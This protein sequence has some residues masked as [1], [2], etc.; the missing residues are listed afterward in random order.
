MCSAGM[1]IHTNKKLGINLYL[2]KLT[3]DYDAVYLAIGAQKAVD[4]PLKGSSLKGVYLGV[5][6]LKN[7]AL[8]KTPETG[9]KTAVIGGG[10]TAVDCART[11]LRLGSEVTIIYRRTRQEMPAEDF[12]ITAAEEEGV[13]FMMLT[14]PVEYRG[15]DSLQ[16]IVLEIMKL[17]EPDSSGR[18]R[19]VGTG[20]YEAH[21]FDTVIAAISQIPDVQFLTEDENKIN[22]EILPLT[23]WST[24]QADEETM[25]TGIANIFAGGDFRRGPATA[26]EAIADGRIAAENIDKFL[27]KQPLKKKDFNFDSKKEKLLKQIDPETYAQYEK[28]QRVHATELNPQERG[29]NFKEVEYSYSDNE[30]FSEASRCLEC[31]CNVNESCFLRKYA[32]NYEVSIEALTG[33][34]NIHPIDDTHPFIRRDENKCIKCGRCV[35]TCSEIQGAG[36]LGYIYRGFDTT[37]APEFGESL[38]NTSCEACGKCIT[39][40]PVGALTPKHLYKKSTPLSGEV[41]YQNCGLCGTACKIQT[42]I[43]NSAVR[44]ISEPKEDKELS[45]NDRN[46]CFYGRFGWQVLEDKN[47]IITPQ[48][49]VNNEWRPASVK[50]IKDIVTQK[51]LTFEQRYAFISAESSLE[52]MYLF[53]HIEKNK[54]FNILNAMS[55]YDISDEIYDSEFD[56]VKP[57]DLKKAEA[58][59]IFGKVSQT[60]RTLCRLAQRENKV[61]LILVKPTESGYNNFADMIINDNIFISL[62]EHCTNKTI[63]I[64]NKNESSIQEI[65]E[66]WTLA[67]DLCDFKEGS[68]VLACSNLANSR[69]LNLMNIPKYD[70]HKISNSLIIAYKHKLNFI[71]NKDNFIIAIDCSFE[72]DMNADM[73]IPTAS[74]LEIEAH[75]LSDFK[76]LSRFENP[77]NSNLF[78]LLLNI[79]Y[80]TDLIPPTQA[81]PSLWN[82]KVEEFLNNLTPNHLTKEKLQQIITNIDVNRNYTNTSSR[83][84]DLMNRIKPI[85]K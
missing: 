64:Y 46:L 41:I 42:D 50:E 15:N 19:P 10:N 45:F 68:G 12:E 44:E 24:A 80:E 21:D 2:E 65:K 7:F 78:Y 58:I 72:A 23:K 62:N 61:K 26:I 33:D 77:K 84:K 55:D 31:G 66:I 17:E 51:L 69:G 3:Q 67:S 38:N 35:R 18:R 28:I 47:R 37:V 25:F 81:E 20:E 54:R 57:E 14:N 85:K 59:V 29:S 30:A 11:A 40:C 4:M 16:Q 56:C 39:V 71:S 13:K 74:Y 83:Q 34:R 53:K 60:V 27:N 49:K 70:N 75:T 48:I 79:C 36:V 1:K 82:M 63:F 22:H 73:F 9:K 32:T 5:D 6:Y 52:E 76:Q 43:C 8:G